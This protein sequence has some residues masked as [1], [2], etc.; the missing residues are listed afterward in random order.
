M[1]TRP[2]A[3][4]G[5]TDSYGSHTL[6]EPPIGTIALGGRRDRSFFPGDLDKAVA[7]PPLLAAKLPESLPVAQHSHRFFRFSLYVPVTARYARYGDMY[8]VQS[9]LYV[10]SVVNASPKC[11]SFHTISACFFRKIPF[12][13]CIAVF[14]CCP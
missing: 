12:S 4:P 7:T 3:R 6:P 14:V 9:K 5:S 8:T 11:F 10:R 2:R 13:V 1:R